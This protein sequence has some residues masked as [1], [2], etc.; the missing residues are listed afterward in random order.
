[1]LYHAWIILLHSKL[2][3]WTVFKS[4][5]QA[6]VSETH[7]WYSDAIENISEDEN[8][9][10]LILSKQ[11]FG[12]RNYKSGKGRAWEP[13]QI[14]FIEDF[15]TLSEVLA[16]DVAGGVGELVGDLGEVV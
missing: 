12:E 2:V 6:L 5:A 4:P 8:W 3:S 13:T 9:L 14:F 1:M 11:A 7:S 16:D 10:E 15:E